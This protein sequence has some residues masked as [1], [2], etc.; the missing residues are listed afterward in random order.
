MQTSILS[1]TS[2]IITGI[3]VKSGDSLKTGDKILKVD[4][5]DSV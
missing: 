2:R 3:S 5:E 4:A 1:A